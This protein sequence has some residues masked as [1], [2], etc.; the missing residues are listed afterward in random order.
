[1]PGKRG[2]LRPLNRAQCPECKS[3]KTQRGGFVKEMG[4]S[5]WKCS[6]CEKEFLVKTLVLS[7]SS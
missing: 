1:M 3:K 7:Q 4:G 2:T 6:S 5:V